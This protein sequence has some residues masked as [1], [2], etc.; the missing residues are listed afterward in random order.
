[1]TEL[2]FLWQTKPESE[3]LQKSSLQIISETNLCIICAYSRV[4]NFFTFFLLLNIALLSGISSVSAAVSDGA[5]TE[6]DIEWCHDV[7]PQY[8]TLG[9][10]WF[11]EN[12]HYSIETRV[13]ASLYEDQVWQYEGNDRIKK[14]IE[15]SKYFV[16]LEIKESE[17]EA[18]SG[19][20]DVTPAGISEKL[21]YIIKA[22]SDGTIL[23]TI[24]TTDAT[25][26]EYMGINVIFKDTENKLIKH[27][28]Y[29]MRVTQNGQEF[30]VVKSQ[31]AKTGM[32]EHWTRPL[33]TDDPVD[34]EITILGMGLPKERT[35]WTGPHEDVLTFYTVP[36]FGLLA[37]TIFTISVMT[38]IVLAQKSKLH[39]T[40]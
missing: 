11:L 19:Q 16:E 12:Y 33:F 31:H 32:A 28:N 39:Q 9:L 35:N 17:E 37:F 13:C 8:K 18:Q 3:N 25:P 38:M 36:E 21:N 1:M 10:K 24:E 6:N 27:V 7:Y 40:L 20:I 4:L 2:T 34:V 26:G 29:D 22:S 14:L 30:L 5:L 23:V 15:R